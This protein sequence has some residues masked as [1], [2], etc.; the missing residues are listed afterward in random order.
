MPGPGTKAPL[1][2]PAFGCGLARIAEAR[3]I[4]SAAAAFPRFIGAPPLLKTIALVASVGAFL[5]L[6]ALVKAL[7]LPFRA[8]RG[9]RK[10]H[11]VPT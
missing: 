3:R 1:I 6:R 7:L 11:S 9:F 5:A 4:G 2:L 10:D 8:L